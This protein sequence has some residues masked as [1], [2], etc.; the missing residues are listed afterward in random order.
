MELTLPKN[1]MCSFKN[2][3]LLLLSSRFRSFF[4]FKT[5]V[6]YEELFAALFNTTEKSDKMQLL[7][8]LLSSFPR[9]MSLLLRTGFPRIQLRSLQDDG[10]QPERHNL[11]LK[12]NCL[13][14]LEKDVP[15]TFCRFRA[16][17]CSRASITIKSATPIFWFPSHIIVPLSVQLRYV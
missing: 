2:S 17:P 1:R 8:L 3:Y 12:N 7:F 14:V 9:V 16:R 11:M 13:A 10:W 15:L 4:F 5:S 6:L